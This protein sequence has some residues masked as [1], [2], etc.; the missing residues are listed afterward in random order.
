MA[1]VLPD[2]Q[3]GW[4][5]SEFV[6]DKPFRPGRDRRAP[7][8]APGRGFPHLPGDPGRPLPRLLPGDREVRPG[9]RRPPG[10]AP[11]R[12]DRDLEEAQAPGGRGGVP[13]G[14]GD[15]PP[16]GRLPG[17]P[18]DLAR[19][20]GL[21]RAP[22]EPD[23]LLR[24]LPAR[25]GRPRGLGPPEAADGGPRGDAPDPPQRRDP[26]PPVRLAA[27]AGRGVRRI[28][29]A[30]ED[31]PQGGRLGGPRPGQPDPHGDDQRPRR[32]DGLEGPR[33]PRRRPGRARPE[34]APRRVSRHPQG[35]DADR[36]RPVLGPG[37][38]P[39]R[40]EDRGV[41]RLHEAE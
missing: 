39:R 11:R 35:A 17:Q 27:L 33:R 12:P 40:L 15:L 4:P 16:R 14:R 13:A 19:R 24:E 18:E 34:D 23:L 29:L 31:D 1:V 22:L 2:G 28:L 38:L 6:T 3:I 30:A 25:P 9:Q 20:P 41:R 26:A 8:D 5:D 7:E 21:L 10:E 32:P 37:P 36:L